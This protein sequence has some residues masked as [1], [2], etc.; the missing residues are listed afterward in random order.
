MWLAFVVMGI[1]LAWGILMGDWAH[2]WRGYADTF[3]MT[4]AK[5][6]YTIIAFALLAGSFWWWLKIPCIFSFLAT[7][8]TGWILCGVPVILASLLHAMG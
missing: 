1:P 8:V 2:F 7:I 5:Y 3:F 4:R 6:E